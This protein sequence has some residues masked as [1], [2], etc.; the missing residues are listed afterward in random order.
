VTEHVTSSGLVVTDRRAVEVHERAFGRDTPNGNPTTGTVGP[1]AATS[2]EIVTLGASIGSDPPVVPPT[3]T[4]QPWAGW[5][6][7]WQT[8]MWNQGV[9][10][11]ARVSTVF[12]CVD[13]N[14]SALASMTPVLKRGGQP[15]SP[16]EREWIQNPQPEL[17]AHWGEFMQQVVVSLEMRGNAY[18]RKSVSYGDGLP[19]RFFV[20]NPDLVTVEW[21][22]GVRAYYVDDEPVD[23]AEI[24][25]LRYLTHAGNQYGL[26]PLEGA[27][28][29]L[30][31]AAAL[32]RYGAMLASKG[33]VPWAVLHSETRLTGNQS[34]GLQQDWV[35]AAARRDG[36]PAVLSGGL[37]LKPL[38]LS[39]KDMA[40]LDLRVFDEQRIASTFGVS[41]FLV[42]LPQPEGMTYATTTGLFE[43]HHRRKLRPLGSNIG[44]ALSSWALPFGEELTLNAS[45]Y[46]QGT[47]A[48]RVATWLPA[49]TAGAITQ[50][51]FR[52]LTGLPSAAS[53]P[54]A[55]A[56]TTSGTQ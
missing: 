35:T 7:E 29:N 20:M 28:G 34:R 4:V 22:N 55:I 14:S 40:L 42:G 24:L 17:Y 37:E 1:D 46:T 26:S 19:R 2:G 51:E 9:G 43:F 16:F 41:P 33:G 13:L 48:E 52:V 30:V 5:P 39:P 47:Q 54:A 38:T 21:R 49:L 12:T 44:T 45:E 31:S 56:S 23:P 3:P 11:Q 18:L 32:E 36:A 53:G 50:D 6:D 10:L 15:V 25:H 8:P 27:R